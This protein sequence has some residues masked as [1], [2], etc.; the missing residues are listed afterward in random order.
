MTYL[1]KDNDCIKM[2]YSDIVIREPSKRAVCSGSFFVG[3]RNMRK[4]KKSSHAL[5]K[6]IIFCLVFLVLYTIAN[7]VIFALTGQEAKVLDT[8]VYAAFSGEMLYCFLIKKFKLH[9]E[10]KIVLGKKKETENIDDYE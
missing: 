8:L 4:T 9:E 5:D 7:T 6:Y 3:E 1:T 2:V 10:A